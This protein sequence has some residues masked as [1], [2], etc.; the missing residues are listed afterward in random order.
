MKP[1]TF[2]VPAGG[3]E[4]VRFKNKKSVKKLRRLLKRKAYRRGTK[5]KLKVTVADAA[6]NTTTERVK[7][8]LKR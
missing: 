4:R 6:G 5:A 3:R 2:S 1:K 7:V 8:T